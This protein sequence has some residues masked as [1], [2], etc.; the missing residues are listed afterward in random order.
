MY[1]KTELT[2]I[3]HIHCGRCTHIQCIFISIIIIVK[4]YF[5]LKLVIQV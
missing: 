1:S 5:I 2:P 3:E 4:P